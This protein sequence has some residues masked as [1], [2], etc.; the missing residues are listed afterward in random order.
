M[1]STSGFFYHDF[2]AFAGE[3]QNFDGSYPRRESNTRTMRDTRPLYQLRGGQDYAINFA[4]HV[5]GAMCH[6]HGGEMLP[7]IGDEKSDISQVYRDG[8]R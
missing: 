6:G 7:Y 8:G 1:A 2:L 4:K 5:C 3:F